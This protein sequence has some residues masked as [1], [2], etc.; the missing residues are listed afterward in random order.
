MKLSKRTYNSEDDFWRI[1]DFLRKAYLKNGRTEKCWSVL[2]WDYWRWHGIE[3]IAYVDL[4]KVVFLW[5]NETGEIAALLNPEGSG[6]AYFH[7]LPEY[8]SEDLQKEMLQTAEEHLC[9]TAEDGSQK[10]TVWANHN[11]HGLKEILAQNAYQNSGAEE[12]NYLHSLD[13]PIPENPPAEGYKVRALGD[14]QDLPG[15]SWASWRAFHPNDPAEEYQGWE[16]YLNI[17]RCP[18]YRRDL[19]IVAESPEGKIVSF[20]TVWFDDVTRSGFFEPVGT[21][22]EHQRKGLARAVIYEGLRRLKWLGVTRAHVGSGTPRADAVY[23]S[24]RFG[25]VE[26][27]EGWKK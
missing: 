18:L 22:P 10:L 7:Y 24:L 5:E 16:W 19:D 21:I 17:Q 25:D 15:R 11:D 27:N 2:R 12:H 1:R 8:R 26:I 13:R 23:T 3:N 14:R 6:Q 4:K 20:C 9:R